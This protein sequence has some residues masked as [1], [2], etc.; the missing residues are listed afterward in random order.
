MSAAGPCHMPCTI[1]RVRV[2]VRVR[3]CAHGNT[4]ALLKKQLPC[5]DHKYTGLTLQQCL[6]R[7]H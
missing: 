5:R 3:M 6:A 2:R 1:V 7:E 4:G